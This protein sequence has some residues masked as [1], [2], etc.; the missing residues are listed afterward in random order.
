[1]YCLECPRAPSWDLSCC[2]CILTTSRDLNT[3]TEWASKWLMSFNPTKCVHLTITRKANPLPSCYSIG[4]SIIQQVNSTKYLGVTI[5]SN[6]SWSE[7]IINI[8]NKANSTRAFLQRNLNRCQQSVKSAC[9]IT[10]VRPILEYASTVW[11]PHQVGDINRIEMVQRLAARFVCNIF[12][13]TASVTICLTNWT[14]Q[15]YSI[16]EIKPSFT[17][18]IS[19]PHDH[20]SQTSTTTHGHSMRYI[21]SY[22]WQSELIATYLYSFFPSSY[23]Q[24]MELP[25]W[26]N[27]IIPQLWSL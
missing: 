15:L 1:M 13:R 12:H 5:T 25:P 7:H 2:C 6:L 11:P 9:Y 18:F 26:R 16:E 24:T 10:Y 20:L 21:H 17:C 23:H 19:V 27:C 4:D 8:T 3:L 22:N 14:G